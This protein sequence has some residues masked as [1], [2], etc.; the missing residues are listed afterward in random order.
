MLRST[1]ALSLFSLIVAA[2]VNRDIGSDVIA[3]VQQCL[4][5]SAAQ[6]DASQVP[7]YELSYES[8]PYIHLPAVF[9]EQSSLA[10]QA[11]A[12]CVEKHA[13]QDFV[14]TY[15]KTAAYKWGNN[16]VTPLNGFFQQ[17]LLNTSDYSTLAI[18]KAIQAARWSP[19]LVHM[20]AAPSQLPFP[21]PPPSPRIA[22][23]VASYPLF[24]VVE[25]RSIELVQ[26]A[27]G[28]EL[29]FHEVRHL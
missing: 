12:T 22:T 17:T 20:G 26:F 23:G 7:E 27:K 25:I 4:T 9:E 29:Y 24:G 10:L 13:P 18:S 5:E 14:D 1:F 21:L 2:R 8:L 6:T 11:L 3:R 16:K 19:A 28:S 15:R